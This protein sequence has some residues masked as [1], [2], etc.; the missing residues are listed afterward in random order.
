MILAAHDIFAA[1]AKSDGSGAVATHVAEGA[2]SSLL[3]RRGRLVAYDQQRFARDVGGEKSF[4]IGNGFLDAVE[5]T[6]GMV[7]RADELPG[8]TKDFVLFDFENGGIGVEAGGEG[9]RTFDLFVYVEVE[10][11]GVHGCKSLTVARSRHEDAAKVKSTKVKGRSVG[12]APLRSH[13]SQNGM[14]G[15]EGADIVMQSLTS[16]VG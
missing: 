15:S 2:K 10:R 1:A 9:V 6:A 7:E 13:D 11:F 4:R 14:T 16:V 12:S 5:F 3:A 8:T